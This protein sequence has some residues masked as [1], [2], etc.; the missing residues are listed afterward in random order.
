MTFSDNHFESTDMN[1]L[2]R[3]NTSETVL[4]QNEFATECK[5]FTC[6]AARYKNT[7]IS[8]YEKLLSKVAYREYS[9]GGEMIIRGY[10]CPSPI[11]DIVS[12]NCNRGRMLKRVT[13]RSRPSYEYCFDKDN[14]LIIVNYCH[15]DAVEILDYLGEDIVFGVT[16]YP[17]SEYEIG[18]IVESKIQRDGRIV[19]FIKALSCY[20]DGVIDELEK[21]VYS[22]DATGLCNAKVFHYLHQE[23]FGLVNYD[24]YIFK[25]DNDGYLKEYIVEMSG[26]ENDIYKVPVKR[27]I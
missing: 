10:Y 13:S 1:F 5:R 17:N 8:L 23:P 7:L 19:S 18:S 11:Y 24:K 2:N 26:F 20:N 12:S 21:E 15:S 25:H 3:Q 9:V 14:K 16:F 6:I 4:L 27:K 22:Y